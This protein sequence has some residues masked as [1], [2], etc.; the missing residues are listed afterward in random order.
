[1]EPDHWIAFTVTIAGP[2]RNATSDGHS[3]ARSDCDADTHGNTYAGSKRYTDSYT[4]SF[5]DSNTGSDSAG[6]SD[7][8]SV[9]KSSLLHVYGATDGKK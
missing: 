5:S 9:G 4:R 6:M 3:D 8:C 1:M 2:V 7:I